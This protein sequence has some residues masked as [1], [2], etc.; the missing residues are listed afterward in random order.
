LKGK[1]LER[2]GLFIAEGWRVIAALMRR[3]FEIE[4][5]LT[6]RYLCGRFRG[7][8]SK[9]AQG[10]AV[11]IL[12][13]AQIE[14]VI[15]FRFHQGIMALARIPER[16]SLEVL[17]KRWRSPHLLVALNGINDAQNVG[18]IVRNSAAFG[19]DAILVDSRS[20]DPY[21]RQ[22]VR[23]S[24]GAIFTVPV[25][26]ESDLAPRLHWL[27]RNFKTKV[28]A[29][30]PRGRHKSLND[31]DLAGNTCFVFGSE[32]AG[33]APEVL[34]IADVVAR[35]PISGAVDSLNVACASAVCLAQAARQKKRKLP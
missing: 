13:K 25:A 15:G 29:T 26:Y 11:Y 3:G 19:A 34:R 35:I 18:L 7:H 22:A 6:T 20:C 5:C 31:V 28:V 9:I 4:S 8:L 27:K 32:D 17:A 24:M 30:S 12:E 10:G 16:R 21:Y 14:K 2:D 33:V 1:H 23:V